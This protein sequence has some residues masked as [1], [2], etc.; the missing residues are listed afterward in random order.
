MRDYVSGKSL[1]IAE[2]LQ[3]EEVT[4]LIAPDINFGNF[5]RY[6]LIVVPKFIRLI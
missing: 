5:T 4:T 3:P 6:L 2:Y 1:D